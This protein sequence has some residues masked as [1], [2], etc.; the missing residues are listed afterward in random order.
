MKKLKFIAVF[1]T[2]IFCF[3]KS[4]SNELNYKI[5]C[6]LNALWPSINM[7]MVSVTPPDTCNY[8]SCYIFNNTDLKMWYNVLQ[9][10]CIKL[11]LSMPDSCNPLICPGRVWNNT[12]NI[13]IY[14]E[15]IKIKKYLIAGGGGTDTSKVPLNGTAAGQPLRNRIVFNPPYASATVIGDSLTND[16]YLGWAGNTLS[17]LTSTV[18]CGVDLNPNG[19]ATIK[20]I[21]TS[22]GNTGLVNVATNEILSYAQSGSH[23]GSFKIYPD[24]FI[25]TGKLSAFRG[26]KYNADYSANYDSLSH[27]TWQ[28][29]HRYKTSGGGGSGNVTAVG[30]Y[31]ASEI[32]FFAGTNKISGN[33]L[34]W[35][36]T[37]NNYL[38]FG[39]S[40]ELISGSI[41]PFVSLNDSINGDAFLQ[42]QNGFNGTS[43]RV[44]VFAVGTPTS[45]P[46][47]NAKYTGFYV[48]SPTY[49]Q[50]P[51]NQ[52]WGVYASGGALDGFLFHCDGGNAVFNARSVVVSGKN[53]FPPALTI[54]ALTNKIG[55]GTLA[56]YPDSFNVSGSATFTA[57]SNTATVY[58]VPLVDNTGHF[59]NDD[60]LIWD[61]SNFT[62]KESTQKSPT[63]SSSYVAMFD[64][65]GSLLGQASA[66][67][68]VSDG[69]ITPLM[70]FSTSGASAVCEVKSTASTGSSFI[71]LGSYNN[72]LYGQLRTFNA[73]FSTAYPFVA[74]DMLLWNRGG[75]LDI[76]TYDNYQI[77]FFTN[78]T[79]KANFNSSGKLYLGGS[80][81]A[82]SQLHIAAGS[83]TANT[84]PL[85]FTQGARETTARAGVMEYDSLLYFTNNTTVGRYAVDVNSK[86]YTTP[87]TSNT[88]VC[89]QYVKSLVCNPA[90]TLAALTITFPPHPRDGMVFRISIS[91]IITSL[92]LNTSDGSTIKGTIIT[93]A[94]NGRGGFVYD[95][96]AN[97]WFQQI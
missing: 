18:G 54:Q 12:D 66:V 64:N 31:V 73:S 63:N 3:E 36:D 33:N 55:I 6:S 67:Y 52:N 17:A 47:T 71:N 8:A 4:Y 72:T 11:G 27:I 62:I 46:A 26:V 51:A 50:F 85:Q 90:G 22:T 80:T 94:V 34:F 10:T 35:R 39:K 49:S 83:T 76:G 48:T 2:A 25:V 86:Q 78:A 9:S 43:A 38:R 57:L 58:H 24:T 23:T 28:D 69:G 88:V 77:T 15:L 45:T 56:S 20:S 82:S 70:T 32:P 13:M 5:H 68:N 14:A 59:Y 81:S 1:I 75:A 92:T 87:V 95:V 93:S 97:A 84:A 96:T 60:K 42:V 21:N 37:T 79:E 7:T 74:N 91:Q 30:S 16:M 89:N 19:S 53:Y 61:V 29:L 44:G 40:P 41:V 65:N